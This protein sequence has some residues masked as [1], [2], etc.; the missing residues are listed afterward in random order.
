MT[1]ERGILLQSHDTFMKKVYLL[2]IMLFIG[3]SFFLT[4]SSII[5][6]VKVIPG[7]QDTVSK[8]DSQFARELF[9]K[10]NIN[11]TE[12][13][14]V[15]VEREGRGLAHSP[16]VWLQAIHDRLPVFGHEVIYHFDEQGNFSISGEDRSIGNITIASAPEIS[17]REAMR[18]AERAGLEGVTN[19][20]L[21]FYNK[22]GRWSGNDEY[23]LAWY[24][25]PEEYSRVLHAVVD[26][27]TGNI[28]SI[29]KKIE[30]P[31]FN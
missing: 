20:E 28:L 8:S 21:G 10:K 13:R 11:L 9:K 2:I 1:T 16:W 24:I 31:T 26:A 7:D 30:P 5:I 19:I 29:Q 15:R 27:H 25:W 22:T 6:S 12:Y 3:V 17:M 23:A 18:I 14:I 4:W